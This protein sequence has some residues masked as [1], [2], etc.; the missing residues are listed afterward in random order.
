MQYENFETKL[1]KI[2][3]IIKTLNNPEI[4]LNDSLNSYKEGM[5]LIKE[6]QQILDN[7]K[8]EITEIEE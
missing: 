3:E 4:K 7:A 6:A 1:E 5:K 8:L 2:N